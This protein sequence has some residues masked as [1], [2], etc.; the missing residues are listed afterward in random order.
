MQPY[1][2]EFIYLK[3][4]TNKV[5]DALSRTLEF[6]CCAIEVHPAAQIRPADL[7]EAARKDS[8]YVQP[9]TEMRQE[10]KK[11]GELWVNRT[12]ESACVWVPYNAT[13]RGKLISEYHETPIAGHLGVKKTYVR[14][15]ERFRWE[16][17]KKEVEEFVRTCNLYQ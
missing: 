8:S 16:G 4:E 6:K 17:L 7:L 14:L 15:F 11:E 9:L 13:L 2:F 5:A 1:R 3:G 10:W 12:G